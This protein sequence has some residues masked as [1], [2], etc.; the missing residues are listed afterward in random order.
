[1]RRRLADWA[2]RYEVIVLEGCDGV[3]K[4]TVAA[5]LASVY[6]YTTVHS[7]RTPDGMDLAG[8]YREILGRPGKLVL[9]RCF[10][11]ELVY[12]PLRHGRSRISTTEAA[13]LATDIAERDGVLVHLTGRPEEIVSRLEARDGQSPLL[14]ETQELLEAY[15]N[16]FAALAGVVPIITADPS[17]WVGMEG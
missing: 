12:G 13:S 17:R 1:M 7:G 9:D 8:R 14:R 16:A 6:G 4:T 10:I 11:S 5:A 15:A 2:A 3:G